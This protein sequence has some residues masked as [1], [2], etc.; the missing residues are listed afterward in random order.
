MKRRILFIMPDMHIGGSVRNFL[1]LVSLMDPQRYDITLILFRREGPLLNQLPDYVRVREFPQV[2]RDFQLP[3][4]E[5]I[6]NLMGTHPSV[7]FLRLIRL[8]FGLIPSFR[9]HRS[10]KEWIFLKRILPPLEPEYDAA[11]GYLQ[12][13]SV[14]YAVDKVTAGTKIGFIRNEYTRGRYD[15]E[16]DAPYFRK[17]DYLGTVSESG[18]EDLSRVFPDL[19]GKIHLVPNV[20]SPVFLRDMAAREES[21]FDGDS[22]FHIVS[23][24]RLVDVKG[25][26][27]AVQ[28]LQILRSQGMKVIWHVIGSGP[29][30]K[31]L[32]ELIANAGLRDSFILE[33]EKVNPY[34]YVRHADLY[35]QTSRSEG[36]CISLQEAMVLGK[37]C[38]STDFDTA[39]EQID[40][41]K[42]GILCGKS[43]V[44]IAEAVKRLMLD[45]HLYKKIQDNVSR[46][47]WDTDSALASFLQ[48]VE[49]IHR[50]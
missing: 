35:V 48:M 14:Y 23:L 15:A 32:V 37:V 19:Q 33:G 10:Q 22:S 20:V 39:R 11:V 9:K 17:L 49:P 12:T 31:E 34:P 24:G 46:I 7:A 29:Q 44:Q 6:L 27:L 25:F 43:G 42:T 40:H 21:P 16:F 50:E 3:W 18:L 1:S 36:W 13:V 8:L 26:D 41:E 38:V 30:E 4:K 5:S 45:I 2:F 47:P 28:A